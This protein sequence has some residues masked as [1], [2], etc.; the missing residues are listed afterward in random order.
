[1]HRSVLN[2]ILAVITVFSGEGG[3][4]LAQSVTQTAARKMPEAK[5]QQAPSCKDR[6]EFRQLDFW[7][8]DWEVFNKD[9]KLSDTR[10]EHILN[11]CALAETWQPV[12]AGHAGR[13][14]STYD[15]LTQKWEYFWVADNAYMSHWTGVL[16]GNEMRF[17]AE[18][19][20][21]GVT[22]LRH[23]S[24]IRM[25]NGSVRELSVGSSDG[26]KTWVTEYDFMWRRIGT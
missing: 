5:I 8:G 10:V 1:M 9:Q 2:A 18:Q 24:L 22:K 7:L 20:K 26:G 25:P 6:P 14:L 19:I 11:G 3:F 21:D 17:D 16:I 4:L 15:P 13:G 12:E 23:W